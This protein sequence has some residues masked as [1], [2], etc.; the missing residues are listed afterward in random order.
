MTGRKSK[1]YE[2]NHKF[3]NRWIKSR[4]DNKTKKIHSI[5]EEYGEY[6]IRGSVKK[7]IK[8]CVASGISE[9]VAKSVW[10]KMA[11]FSQYAFNK[12]HAVSYS[13]LSARTAW[14]SYY[15][16]VEFMVGV[17]NSYIKKQDKVK[18]YLAVCKKKDIKI[19]PPDVNKSLKNF[20]YD[21]GQ[22]RF[23]L[24]GLRNMGKISEAIIEERTARGEFKTLMDLV[25]RM[26]RYQKFN[27]KA[28][29]SLIYAGALDSFEGTRKAKIDALATMLDFAKE[30]K[31]A[32]ARQQL[33]FF[34]LFEEHGIPYDSFTIPMNDTEEIEQQEKLQ[35]E[36][37]YAG[38]YITAH[39]L[40]IF[41][42]FLEKNGVSDISFLVPED[43]VSDEM[44]DDESGVYN[45]MPVK[46]AGI[47]KDMEVRY[48]RTK[49]EAMCTFTLEDQSATIKCVTFPKQ[50]E[51]YNNILK[52]GN[53][54]V[55]NGKLQKDD[56]GA[57]IRVEKLVNAADASL[58]TI[59]AQ[60]IRVLASISHAEERAQYAALS[61]LAY[62]NPGSTH[63]AFSKGNGEVV[64]LGRK[65]EFSPEV[66]NQIQI[67][68]GE[69]NV[70][71]MY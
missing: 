37:R 1:D 44:N 6:F 49:G 34:G 12:S 27:K 59:E 30:E 57:Q 42:D 48:T 28:L 21:N 46:V 38:F 65:I 63:M 54:V 29:E 53:I 16:P 14:L 64:R 47:I 7:N 5:I 24:M 51:K 40:D 58:E 17:L 61:D 22:I 41:A 4:R 33:T 62:N 3:Q 18:G 39:P 23:G 50:K 60:A 10:D 8:G 13:F 55:L 67:I 9:S 70:E 52:E 35:F 32:F 20:S 31:T 15:Y 71:V 56:F 68:F 26:T 45:N 25:S 11:K 66:L 69:Q 2:R 43:T 36:E 19:L